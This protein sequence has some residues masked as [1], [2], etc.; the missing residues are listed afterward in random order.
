ML[1]HGLTNRYGRLSTQ[2]DHVAFRRWHATITATRP[3]SHLA[4]EMIPIVDLG[5]FRSGKAAKA[6]ANLI[7]EHWE[8][9]S[10]D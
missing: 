5:V 2:I 3:D 9:N 10:E 6:A 8:W 4:D 1:L 7:V